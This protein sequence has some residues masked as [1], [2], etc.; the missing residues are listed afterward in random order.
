MPKTR[1]NT[2]LARLLRFPRAIKSSIQGLFSRL[3]H[4]IKAL[5][6][7]AFT[8][9]GRG[10]KWGL[11]GAGALLATVLLI[12]HFFPLV[13]G[14]HNLPG[15]EVPSSFKERLVEK[16]VLRKGEEIRYLNSYAP[17][18]HVENGNLLAQDRLIRFRKGAD[19]LRVITIPFYKIRNIKVREAGLFFPGQTVEIISQSADPLSIQ[20]PSGGLFSWGSPFLDTLFS[21]H[22]C[23]ELL[24]NPAPSR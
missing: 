2:R 14:A 11:L 17:F 6:R 3:I 5:V 16:G 8:L 15:R 4:R 9:L 24:Q 13:T 23:T 1:T 21:I 7:G 22:H 20:L 19:Q 18:Y 10:L 12:M